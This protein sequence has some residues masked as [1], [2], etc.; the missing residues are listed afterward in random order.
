[1]SAKRFSMKSQLTA[2]LDVEIFNKRG[3]GKSRFID[4]MKRL[5][6]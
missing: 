2:T 6:I 1:M 4:L 3:Y 5:F